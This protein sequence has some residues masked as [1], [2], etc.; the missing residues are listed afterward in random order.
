MKSLTLKSLFVAVLSLFVLTANARV[1]P[2]KAEIV[3][4]STV[5][6]ALCKKN[7]ETN[8][9]KVKG[10]RKVTADF[11]KKEITVVYNPRRIS[12]EELRKKISEMGYD[13]DDVK[14]N[15]RANTLLKHKD[16]QEQK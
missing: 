4:K 13:A 15:N 3:I 1:Q 7:V 14:A 8:L 11:N 12:P 10:V 2:R 5:E 6:C 16:S 9:G